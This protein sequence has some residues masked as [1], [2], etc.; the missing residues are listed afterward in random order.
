MY[1][2]E[3]SFRPL[4]APLK[5]RDIFP[6]SPFDRQPPTQPVSLMVNC[7]PAFGAVFALRT[8]GRRDFSTV[9]AVAMQA[10]RGVSRSCF[11]RFAR[12]RWSSERGRPPQSTLMSTANMSGPPT[13]NVRNRA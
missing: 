4:A 13:S 6:R 10:S 12:S 9:M 7:A 11:A 8:S 5:K 1:L 3:S 2:V